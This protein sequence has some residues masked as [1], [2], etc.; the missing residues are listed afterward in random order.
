MLVAMGLSVYCCCDFCVGL[1][2]TGV[3]LLDVLVGLH[4]GTPLRLFILLLAGSHGGVWTLS[5]VM[6]AVERETRVPHSD[7]LWTRV[8]SGFLMKLLNLWG[9]MRVC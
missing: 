7:L 4:A 8:F 6:S 2:V 3:S 9:M 1:F 5:L